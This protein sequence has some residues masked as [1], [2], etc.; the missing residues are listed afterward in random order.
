M[1]VAPNGRAFYSGP[2]HYEEARRQVEKSLEVDETFGVA[3]LYLAY[4]DL[5]TSARR[6][7]ALVELQRAEE[8]APENAAT[9]K[10]LARA[11][12]AKG[13]TPQADAEMRKAQQR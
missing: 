5:Q 6:A 1:D 2:D 13:M 10:A 9:H 11:F 3:H 12:T 8:L 7:D 4:I